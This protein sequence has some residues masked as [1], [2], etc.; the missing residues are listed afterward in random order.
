MIRLTFADYTAR[1]REFIRRS[2]PHAPISQGLSATETDQ[3][4]AFNELALVLFELQFALVEP[5][6]R[7]CEIRGVSLGMASQWTQIPAIPVS[8]FKEMEI[9]SLG[10]AER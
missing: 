1:L 10:Q 2:S 3:D 7:F 9:S 6:L 5:Y 4:L 8:A